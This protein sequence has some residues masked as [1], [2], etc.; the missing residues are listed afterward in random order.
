MAKINLDRGLYDWAEAE[1]EKAIDVDGRS[2]AIELLLAEIYL[3]KG[4]FNSAVKLLK[5]LHQ[6]DQSNP[7]ISRLLE[8]AMRLPEEQKK[9]VPPAASDDTADVQPAIPAEPEAE[10]ALSPTEVLQQALLLPEVVGGLLCNR[11]GLVLDSEWAL[12]E[13]AETT[14]A[15][16]TESLVHIDN[17]LTRHVFGTVSQLLVE[18]ENRSFYVVSTP[19]GVF[20]FVATPRVNLG[21]MRM[22]LGELVERYHG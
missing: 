20:V 3:Y 11:E 18:T 19:N 22:K 9:D 8:I 7:H 13:D 15:A 17:E 14:G 10:P 12:D 6:S 2:R 4:D 21:T 1:L 16:F 5:V